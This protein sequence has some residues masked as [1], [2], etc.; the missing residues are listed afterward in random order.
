MWID[1]KKY[2]CTLTVEE[3]S[4]NLQIFASAKRIVEGN[5]FEIQDLR[6]FERKRKKNQRREKV[7]R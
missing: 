5:T 3:E 2:C 6:R 7:N 4:R 1:K